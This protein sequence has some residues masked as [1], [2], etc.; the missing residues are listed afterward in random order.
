[1]HGPCD[2]A[3][4]TGTDNLRPLPHNSWGG[5]YQHAN[6][7]SLLERLRRWRV[8]DPGHNWKQRDGSRQGTM[9]VNLPE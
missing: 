2:R 3:L 6:L 1:M 4:R 7:C 8:L 9:V 5:E